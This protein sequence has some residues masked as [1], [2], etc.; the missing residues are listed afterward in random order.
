V[1]VFQ[2]DEKRSQEL[3]Q[4]VCDEAMETASWSATMGGLLG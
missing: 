1:L 3:D 4:E 2:R